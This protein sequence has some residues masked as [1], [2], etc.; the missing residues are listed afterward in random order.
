MR[1]LHSFLYFI[2]V[3]ALIAGLI[4]CVAISLGGSSGNHLLAIG[5]VLISVGNGVR[6]NGAGHTPPRASYVLLGLAGAL[7]LF[8]G[9]APLS[10]LFATLLFLP[11]RA[12]GANLGIAIESHKA[13]SSLLLFGSLIGANLIPGIAVGIPGFIC[14]WALTGI[15]QRYY[16]TKANEGA[17]DSVELPEL[18]TPFAGGV[19]IAMLVLLFLPYATAFDYATTADNT[20]RGNTLLLVFAI[21]WFT[22]AAGLAD[23]ILNLTLRISS[24]LLA[25]S[26]FYSLRFIERLSASETY[27]RFFQDQRILDLANAN[28]PLLAEENPLYLPLMTVL[29]FAIPTAFV[30]VFLRTITSTRRHLSAALCGIAAAFII[31][32]IAPREIALSSRLALTAGSF[33]AAFLLSFKQVHSNKLAAA[34]FSAATIAACLFLPTTNWQPTINLS[35]RGNYNWI[36]AEGS[37]AAQL[38]HLERQL[39]TT[40]QDQNYQIT[41]DGRVATAPLPNNHRSYLQSDAFINTLTADNHNPILI[42][43]P[44][45]LVNSSGGHSLIKLYADAQFISRRS[46]LR[47]ELFRQASMRLAEDGLCVLRIA[48]D[49]LT[50]HVAPQIAQS[51]SDVFSTSKVLIYSDTLEI[52]Y[53]IFVG[54]NQEIAISDSAE[55]IEVKLTSNTN[56]DTWMLQGPWR[57]VN[58]LL[59]ANRPVLN[60]K[61]SKY[62]R[63][64]AVLTDLADHQADDTESLLRFYAAHLQSQEYSVHDTY[65][66]DNPLSTETTDAAL[67]ELMIVTKL[68]PNSLQLKQLWRNVGLVLVESREISWIDTYFGDLYKQGWDEDFV[69]LS[70]AHAALE[71]LDFDAASSLCKTLLDSSP[72]HIAAGALLELAQNQQQVP[73]D[74]HVGHNH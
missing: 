55:A 71:S 60:P 64:S 24:V 34:S 23:I 30:A 27:G 62:H 56:V 15:L 16:P 14:V 70:L 63:A 28:S 39:S 25:S 9:M 3:G 54:S 57:P 66:Q 26:A 68:H 41:F 1:H 2:G 47:H 19:A 59:A 40:Y 20:I 46:L 36:A 21:S 13:N 74:G 43:N 73:R 7:P 50:P 8:A 52:P 12:L 67:A 29:C 44:E 32:A 72:Q 4:D 48:T 17:S 61:V 35:A 33:I 18:L 65:L 38:S 5:F 53:L 49:E 6:F 37:S 45:Q 42:S 22:L 10:A 69:L 51:F 58:Y 11:L 31:I